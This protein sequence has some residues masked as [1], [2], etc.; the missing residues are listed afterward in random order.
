MRVLSLY[1][2]PKDA[3]L[4]DFQ[5]PIIA[6]GIKQLSQVALCRSEHNGLLHSVFPYGLDRR[7]ERIP[8]TNPGTSQPPRISW[9]TTL[10]KGPDDVLD[11]A[12]S[13]ASSALSIS[14]CVFRMDQASVAMLL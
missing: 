5:K 3:S 14:F 10:Q 1:P 6:N 11:A 7:R 12:G 8:N 13:G 9:Y 4:P 2:Y